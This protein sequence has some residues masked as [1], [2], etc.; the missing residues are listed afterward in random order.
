M[1]KKNCLLPAEAE[2]LKKAFIEI[3]SNKNGLVDFFTKKTNEQRINFLKK[4]VGEEADFVLAKLE[5]TF[6]MP[7]QK[8]AFTNFIFKELY[9]TKPLY[10]GVNIQQAKK[11]GK[12]IDVKDLKNKSEEEVEEILNEYL[13]EKTAT[14]VSKTFGR[15][16]ASNNLALFEERL[17]GSQELKENK[18]LLSNLKKL[19]SLS[20]LGALSPEST[21]TFMKSFVEQ[22]LGIRVTMEETVALD[23]I[24]K[25]HD[26]AFEKVMDKNVWNVTNEENVYNYFKARSELETFVDSLKEDTFSTLANKLIKARSAALLFDPKSGK[27]SALY[28]MI[29]TLTG[30]ASLVLTP[31]TMNRKD[32]KFIERV[33]NHGKSLK[34]TKSEKDFIWKQ[35]KFND[36]IYRLFDYEMSRLENLKDT[37]KFFG[38]DVSRKLSKKTSKIKRKKGGN[39]IVNAIERYGNALSLAPKYLAGYT[40]MLGG[41]SIRAVTTIKLAKE[42]ALLEE[43]SGDLK[44]GETV[45][46]RAEELRDKAYSFNPKSTKASVIRKLGINMAHQV[47]NTESSELLTEITS[48]WIRAVKIKDVNVGRWLVPFSKI[49][50]TTISKSAKTATGYGIVKSIIDFKQASKLKG[51]EQDI[52]FFKASTEMVKQFGLL[53]AVGLLS[54]IFLDPEDY[55]APYVSLKPNQLELAETRGAKGG[56]YVKIFGQWVPLK[57]LPGVNMLLGGIMQG[58][59]NLV[60][61]ENFFTG[62]A[63]GVASNL[64]ELPLIRSMNFDEVI[65]DF[66]NNPDIGTLTE[67]LG[68]NSED[69]TMSFLRNTLPAF[70]PNYFKSFLGDNTT[71]DFLGNESQKKG[72]LGWVGFGTVKETELLL[73]LMRLDEK[74]ELPTLTDPTGTYAKELEEK[75]GEAEYEKYLATLKKDYEE[76]INKLIKNKSYIKASEESKKKSWN[77]RR[78]IYILDKLK[79]KN[80]KTK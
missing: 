6:F 16:K 1:A 21:E 2:Q 11:M 9:Q 45:E 17:L 52:A 29:P 57:Y 73:E 74:K 24:N 66:I 63:E 50:T 14:T 53:L 25:K 71:Y 4:Y 65:R 48:K 80:N 62:Y 68:F 67:K 58:R 44:D 42:Q 30:Y 38:E 78:K 5:K 32:I 3:K 69:T 47:N 13:D 23:K 28:Q 19:D 70:I 56:G 18:E 55:I 40:D 26:E 51:E 61:E 46:Q 7:N 12:E 41:S 72:V 79:I 8:K 35:I 10:K 54:S 37:Y 39:K 60:R 43:K 34:F 33:K 64:I 20:Y 15:L 75:M 31:G 59:Q 22:E 49:A 77:T 76:S 36:K 27:N